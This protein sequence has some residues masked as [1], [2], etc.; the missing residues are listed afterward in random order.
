MV[1][2]AVGKIFAIALIVATSC[3]DSKSVECGFGL[4]PQ[5]ST[6][7]EDAKQCIPAGCGNGVLVD[8]PANTG[9]SFELGVSCP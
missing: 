5:G 1:P 2:W 3:L 8:G 4:C 6:C 9:E 7:D